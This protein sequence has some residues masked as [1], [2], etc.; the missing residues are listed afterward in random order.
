MG[1]MMSIDCWALDAIECRLP[2]PPP[3]PLEIARYD[4]WPT[5]FARDRAVVVFRRCSH[6]ARYR[7]RPG[8]DGLD[9]LGI[10]HE[11]GCEWPH[12]WCR[13]WEELGS[14]ARARIAR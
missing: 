9:Q 11:S 10:G 7:V 3:L 14:R 8:D 4:S 2:A 13:C 5:S 6:D 12:A 1:D